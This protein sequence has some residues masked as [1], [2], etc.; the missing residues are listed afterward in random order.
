MHLE[1]FL[2]HS[3]GIVLAVAAALWA[4]RL[5]RLTGKAK[6]WLFMAAGL[7]LLAA[8]SF[9]QLLVHRGVT[10]GLFTH[11]ALIDAVP[12]FAYAL[13]LAGVVFSGAIFRERKAGLELLEEQ[14]QRLR[15]TP[16][17]V[18][19]GMTASERATRQA[20]VKAGRNGVSILTALEYLK[21]EERRI[22]RVLQEWQATFDAITIPVFVYDRTYRLI[23]ANR[24]YLERAGMTAK[25]IVG[26]PYFDIFPKLGSPIIDLSQNPEKTAPNSEIRLTTGEIFLSKNYPIYS[27]S[28]EYRY[29][30]HTLQEVTL[31]KQAEKSIRRIRLAL[32]VVAGCTHEMLRAGDETH[33]LQTVCKVVVNSGLYRVAWIAYAEHDKNKSLQLLAFHGPSQDAGQLP[34]STWANTEDNRSPVGEAINTGKT[35]VVPDLIHDPKFRNCQ[36]YAVKNHLASAVGLPLYQGADVW[37]GLVLYSDEPFAFSDEEIDVLEILSASVS[38][39]ITAL[40]STPGDKPGLLP[41]VHNRDET[42]ANLEKIIVALETV[43]EARHPYPSPHQRLVGDIGMAIALEMGLPDEQAYGIRLAGLLHDVGEIKVPEEILRK[44]GD[45]TE[46]ERE[47][48]QRHTQ[49]GYEILRELDLPWPLAQTALQHHER[50]DG[51]GYPNGLTGEKILL[52]AK[53]IAVADTIEAVSHQRQSH[54]RLGIPAALAEVEKGKGTLFDPAVVEAALRL[55]R[56]KGYQVP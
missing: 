43:I 1:E 15:Q 28:N 18:E 47:Q 10:V 19:M 22:A 6:A 49:E 52:E 12:V 25:D 54:P 31:V 13:L 20:L 41:L 56:E 5:I 7:V 33:M 32:K 50:M 40:H 51:S 53:I 45:L 11:L 30:L 48:L 34:N 3:T 35:C 55:F 37:G 38:F 29:T 9:G 2:L 8:S 26:K 27:E 39:G 17:E 4:L 23:R 42:R 16:P 46:D 36:R 14:L 24:A 21:H 44:T